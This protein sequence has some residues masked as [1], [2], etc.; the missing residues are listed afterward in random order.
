M[1]LSDSCTNQNLE[2]LTYADGSFDVVITQDVFEHINNPFSAFF[3]IARIL[4]LGGGHFF[5]VPIDAPLHKTVSRITIEN[6]VRKAV[7]P[8][9]YHG[10]PIDKENGS[11][12]TYDW[13]NDICE[14]IEECSGMKTSIVEFDKYY[15]CEENIRLGLEAYSLYVLVSRKALD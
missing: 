7:L 15:N 5:T 9:I 11:L 1:I 3:E 8:E 13:G 14:L 4:K 2:N 6:G 10:N 12:V